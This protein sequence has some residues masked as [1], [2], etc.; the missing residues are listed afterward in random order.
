MSKNLFIIDYSDKSF[1]VK[2]DDTLKLSKDLENL[3][4]KYVSLN[5][6]YEWLFASIR[7]ESVEL[8]IK[9]GTIKRYEYSK[10]EIK[11]FNTNDNNCRSY[12]NNS[13]MTSF[14]NEFRNCFDIDKNYSGKEI[15]K[16][17]NYLQEYYL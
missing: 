12:Y 2:G 4:G 17:I 10:E 16:T 7:K 11:K 3:G 15:F 14:F 13:K 1:I 5:I 9:T 6:G 8:Y